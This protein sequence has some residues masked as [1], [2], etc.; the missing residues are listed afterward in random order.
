MD[1]EIERFIEESK[2]FEVGAIESIGGVSTWIAESLSADFMK[3]ARTTELY[4]INKYKSNKLVSDYS[5]AIANDKNAYHISTLRS[6]VGIL[7]AFDKIELQTTD[8]KNA[9]ETLQ[10]IFEHFHQCAT[11]LKRRHNRRE[12]LRID[13]EY[14]VQ[15]L[16]HALFKLHFDDVR[17]E[18][19]CPSYAGGSKRMDFLLKEEKIAIEVKMT[20]DKLKDKEIGDQLIIDI[21]NYKKHPDVEKLYCFVYDP[22]PYIS[23]PHGLENDLSYEADGF[24]VKVFIRPQ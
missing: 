5:K 11:Q 12:T 1:K 8:K 2:R 22:E 13:D 17:P 16:L 10:T 9:D 14:D 15:D 7:E 23:N 20:R 3:W 24:L 4:L 6:L 18:E 19:W 21:A